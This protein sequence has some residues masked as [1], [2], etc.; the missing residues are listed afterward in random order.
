ML[1]VVYSPAAAS[2][3]LVGSDLASS[4]LQA[5]MIFVMIP[6]PV[7]LEYTG[8]VSAVCGLG[9][10][11]LLGFAMPHRWLVAAIL[12]PPPGG[13]VTPARHD[14]DEAPWTPGQEP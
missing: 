12:E 7:D 11:V 13:D 5:G 10:L 14:P 3:G 9:G 8:V 6:D 4:L 1:A 2:P